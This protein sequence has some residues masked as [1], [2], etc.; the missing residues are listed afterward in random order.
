MGLV[1]KP[2]RMAIRTLGQETVQFLEVADVEI[3]GANGFDAILEDAIFGVIPSSE[4][5]APPA[6]QDIEEM[7][8]LDGVSFPSFL[9]GFEGKMEIGVII[10]A[11]CA[12]MWELGERKKG[13]KDLAIGV[14]STL[15]WVLTGPK[16]PLRADSLNC[17]RIAVRSRDDE[18]NENIVRAFRQDFEKV[19]DSMEAMSAGDRFALKQMEETVHWDPAV[20]RYWVGLPWVHGREAA[21]AILNSVDS[22]KMALDR[23]FRSAG[24]LRR[25]PERRRTAFKDMQEFWEEGK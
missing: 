10:G 19:D 5:D 23:L 13:P 8:H 14:H 1:G 7:R 21:A 6:A 24:R 12:W 4:E 9:D 18:I 15:G 17:F 16:G 2:V 22:D 11:E 3:E 20:Q 25:D